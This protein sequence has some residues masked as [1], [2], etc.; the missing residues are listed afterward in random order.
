[1][2]VERVGEDCREE[3]EILLLP[4]MENKTLISIIV[5]AF[6][7]EENLEVSVQKIGESLANLRDRYSFELIF[8]NDGSSD[9]TLGIL[10]QLH[11]KHSEWVHY[12]SFSRNFGHMSALRCG[13]DHARGQ[14]VICMDADLQHPPAYLPV[15]LEK[16][17]EGYEIV[18][19]SRQDDEKTSWFKRVCSQY[20]YSLMNRFS[21][22]TIEPG[23]ADFRL[24]D[25][26][27]VD[28]IRQSQE[29]D[30][31]IRGFIPWVGFR[32]FM[33]PYTP[34]KRFAGKS[35]YTFKKMLRLALNGI[36]AFSIRPLRIA[37]FLGVV[38]SGLAFLYAI[39]AIYAHS[40]L[41]ETV[42]GWTSVLLSVLIMGGLQLLT[43]GIIGEYLGRLFIQAKGRPP[44]IV[45]E[46]SIPPS[47]QK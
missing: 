1:M 38:I 14:A 44:Y 6:N 23:A 28:L 24:L 21:D 12:L 4:Y 20:F 42:Q 22:V 32:Q 17:A 45:Q 3:V 7:E 11:Q 5:P 19:T 43:L 39:Y 36:T 2:E 31:F 29:T 13:Y 40:V 9:K 34:D 46:G 47:L 33:I 37:T 25:R 10:R 27:V 26:K 16:W 8:V 30:L 15:F 18:F 41:K 35:K